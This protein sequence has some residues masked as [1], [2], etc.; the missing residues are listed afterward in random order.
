VSV[1]W[2]DAVHADLPR[3]MEL[4]DEQDR[5]F[6]GTGVAVD[7]PELFYPEGETQHAFYPYKPPILRVRIAEVDGEIVGFKYQEAVPETCVVTG[8]EDAMKTLGNELTEDAHWAKS[9]GFRSGWGLIPS[10]FIDG[11]RYF[12]RRHPHIR[13]WKSLTPVGIDFSELGD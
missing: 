11:M 10:K 1:T 5:R 6:E 2:R 9:K 7:R 3:I 4:W 8:N 12:L 13:P